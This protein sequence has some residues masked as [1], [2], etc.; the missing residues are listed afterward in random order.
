[1]EP[2]NPEFIGNLARVKIRRGDRDEETKSL[3]Q[4]LVYKDS[5]PTWRDWA[6]L[7]LVRFYA[8][9]I[10]PGPTTLPAPPR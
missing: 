2:D 10:E 3:L 9:P 5:R 8:R 4:E 1:M 7:E 6:K